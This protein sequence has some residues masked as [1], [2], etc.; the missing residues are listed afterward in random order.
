MRFSYGD[1][2]H[3]AVA[4]IPIC[5][6]DQPD[7]FHESV[8]YHGRAERGGTSVDHA[9]GLTVPRTLEE[10]CDRART[11]LI[12]YDMQSGIV[13]QIPDGETITER[14]AEVR[15][16]A[17]EAG[18]RIV[19]TRHMSL[20]NE[21][22]GA[23]QL[24]T[25]IAW[26]HV[27]RAADVKPMFLRDSPGFQ[28]TPALTPAPTEAIFDKITMSAFEGTPLNITLRDCAITAFVI[29]GIALEVGIEPTV[30]H[31]MDLGYIP[32]VVTDAC[33][34]RDKPAAKRALDSLAFAGGSLQTDVKT[35]CAIFSR[36]R[37][38]R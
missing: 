37:V 2:D 30:R 20:P 32:V 17:R 8:L 19:Y 25:A 34:S 12:I 29:V 28:I 22:A 33:G 1:N 16:A 15:Q 27:D 7:R 18:V 9:F 35:I 4:R 10:V 5:L 21:L 11:A 31:A 26:Q 23:T 6:E 24:R 3:F 13:P 38:A 36:V 14:V